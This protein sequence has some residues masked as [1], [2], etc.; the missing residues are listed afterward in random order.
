MIRVGSF[1]A[2]GVCKKFQLLLRGGMEK[3][4]VRHI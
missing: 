4:R 1:G 2:F 3:S